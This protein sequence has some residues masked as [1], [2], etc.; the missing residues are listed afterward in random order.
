M[1]SFRALSTVSLLGL[2]VT[3][4]GC[5]AES[6]TAGGA[7]TAGTTRAADTVVADQASSDHG[8]GR[9]PRPGGG[10]D[11]LLFAALHEPINLTAAQKTTIEGALAANKPSAPPSFDKTRVSALAAGIRA[12]KVEA[13]AVKPPG[14]DGFAAHQA[15]S[16]KALATLHA[17]LTPEQRTALVAAVAKRG[18]QMHKD[19]G[20]DGA[21]PPHMEHGGPPPGGGAMGPMGPMGHML[22]GL[23]LTK[24]QEEAI[25]AK[26]DAQRPAPPSEADR[27]AMKAQHESMRTAMQAKLQTFASDSFDATAFVTP[28]DGAMKPPADHADRFAADLTFITSILDASQREKLAA[29]IEAGPPA[30]VGRP[31]PGAAKLQQGVTP[32]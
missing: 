12:G 8:P 15:A 28:P 20:K 18:E 9:G 22:E 24:A 27:A 3:L 26:L 17:T 29:R 21:R 25:K 1:I 10:P 11:F 5:S 2:L 19:F 32:Q 7:D 23:D 30:R 31:A 16:A 4:A 14:E 13:S 6:A